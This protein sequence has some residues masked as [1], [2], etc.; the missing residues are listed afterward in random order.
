MVNF[1]RTYRVVAGTTGTM[2]FDIGAVDESTGRSIHCK[3]SV[4][5]GDSESNNAASIDLYNLSDQSLAILQQD[6]CTVDLQAGYEGDCATILQG[7]VN[8]IET[9]HDGA[10]VC[11][12]V[13]ITDGMVATRDTNL[14][15]SYRG[16]IS[17]RKILS[18]AAA[19]MGCGILYSPTCTFPSFKNFSFVG[20]ATTLFHQVCGASGNNFSIQ[21]GVIQVC[22]ANEAITALAYIIS[23][24]TGLIGYPERLY[25]SASTSNTDNAN[26]S[27]RKT[28]IG[29][30]VKFLMNGHVQVNDYVRLVSTYASGT[31]RV[32]KIDASGDSEGTGE[33][34]WCC[35][36]E[37]L[38][39]S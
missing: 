5:R 17:G 36:A 1:K 37:L 7:T 28:Q 6:N 24:D 20:S 3:F 2:G 16:A 39:V 33:D 19:Q 29:W 25:D 34:S 4:E 12:H 11:T 32:S 14:S 23:A 30:K 18:D 22:A 10:D 21:N 35:T 13:D 15:I 9:S 8:Y 31:Y 27:R 38:G 26:T